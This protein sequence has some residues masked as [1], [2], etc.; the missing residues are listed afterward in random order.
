A[1]PLASA[2]T[3]AGAASLASP[4]TPAD[5]ALL[6]S[7]PTPADAARTDAAPRPRAPTDA[8]PHPP[9]PTDAAPRPRRRDAP[10]APAPTETGWLLVYG[11]DLVGSR[12]IV[13]GG[14]WTGSVPNPIEV[15]VG[16]HSVAVVRR[17]GTRLPPKQ[18]DVASFH[19]PNRPLRITW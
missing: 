1:A 7:A 5:A 12:V 15:A 8:A 17:D 4:P 6:A 13:D 19:S 16:T 18:V 10:P 11:D 3:P 14:A 9:A 2:P